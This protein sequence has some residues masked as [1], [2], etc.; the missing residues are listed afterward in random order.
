MKYIKLLFAPILVSLFACNSN[1]EKNYIPDDAY[2]VAR[3]DLG[4]V[5]EKMDIES[6]MK[7]DEVKD[8]LD[9]SKDELP[10]FLNEIMKDPE[11]S[12]INFLKPVTIFATTG[13]DKNRDYSSSYQRI[14]VIVRIDNEKKLEELLKNLDDEF[15]MDYAHRYDEDD[16]YYKTYPKNDN[17]RDHAF[18]WNDDVLIITYKSY[19]RDDKDMKSMAEDILNLKSEESLIETNAAFDEFI[20]NDNDFD[21][22]ANVPMITKI[23]K[24]EG[25]DLDEIM[26]EVKNLKQYINNLGGYSIHLNFE[27]DEI[28]LSSSPHFIDNSVAEE[29][30]MVGSEELP[31]DYLK[32]LTSNGNS[33]GAF[34]MTFNPETYAKLLDNKTLNK[35]IKQE[36]G[37]SIKELI[38]SFNGNVAGS[39]AEMKEIEV[40][41]Y[42]YKWDYEN[43]DY[44]KEP[45]KAKKT[46]PIF[47]A[48]VGIDSK[49]KLSKFIKNIF[50][51]NSKME[52]EGNRYTVQDSDLGEI[53]FIFLDD[54]MFISNDK[55]AKSVKKVGAWENP[56][57]DDLIQTI[58][59]NPMGIYWSLN[60]KDYPKEIM[61]EVPKSMD[62]LI[63][64]FKNIIIKSD[65]NTS[66]ISIGLNEGEGNSLH[67][68]LKMSIENASKLMKMNLSNNSYRGDYGEETI[69]LIPDD[70]G[71]ASADYDYEYQG[72]EVEEDAA[73]DDIEAEEEAY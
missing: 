31:S 14:G 61:K 8:Q 53:N 60:S 64:T 42:N 3:V 51:D 46:V 56:K 43:Y 4:S 40:T 25:Q 23:A 15:N 18:A 24:S 7:L 33:L 66:S 68:I 17:R 71:E 34:G 36:T 12:G 22:F 70:Y 44:I 5:L 57:N 49:S 30:S 62:P 47:N 55:K 26:G 28:V 37:L 72:E 50:K 41:K 48:Q 20:S 6:L 32:L 45:Y 16:D 21:V 10:D 9:D 11:E 73:A 1:I 29:L 27:D 69:E 63:K 39:I 59:D 52:K 13:K 35:N 65:G 54:R 2:I 38:T 67:R 19:Y 58:T